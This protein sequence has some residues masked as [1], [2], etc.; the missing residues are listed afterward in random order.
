MV[1][2]KQ[3]LALGCW[4]LA[5]ALRAKNQEPTAV[6]LQRIVPALIIAN[7]DGFVDA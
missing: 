2:G 4:L 3:L 6:F 7:A 5:L 1:I